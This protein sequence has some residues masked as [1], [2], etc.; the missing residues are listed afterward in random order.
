M[1]G[2]HLLAFLPAGY[3]S[4]RTTCR[5]FHSRSSPR[6]FVGFGDRR[7]AA[8]PSRP[9]LAPPPHAGDDCGGD[10]QQANDG[11]P[12]PQIGLTGHL[13]DPEQPRRGVPSQYARHAAHQPVGC[14]PSP[15][16][17]GEP[18]AFEPSAHRCARRVDRSR[19]GRCSA[20]GV[21][22]PGADIRYSARERPLSSGAGAPTRPMTVCRVFGKRAIG[23]AGGQLSLVPSAL[24]SHSG[25]ARRRATALK[26]VRPARPG[27]RPPRSRGPGRGRRPDR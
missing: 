24:R 12:P 11:Q 8:H 7:H 2:G 4:G 20:F 14:W 15:A 22:C 26:H 13:A 17:T 5:I 23:S 1:S 19:R 18:E 21:S 16:S 25:V 9:P 10:H 27:R 3:R 6:S